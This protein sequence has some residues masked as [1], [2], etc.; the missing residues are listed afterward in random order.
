MLG[1]AM[2]HPSSITSHRPLPHQNQKASEKTMSGWSDR[3]WERRHDIIY[4][5]QVSALYHRKRERFYGFLDKFTSSLA[6]VAGSAAMSD[7]LSTTEAKSIAGGL[8]AI[9]TIPGIVFSWAERA[10]DHAVLASRF[11]ALEADVEGLG[12]TDES[13]FDAMM[14]RAISI[15]SEEPPQLATLTKICQN[16]VARASGHDD[17]VSEIGRFSRWT[18]HWL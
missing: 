4:K 7:F 5:C 18:A 6:L 15:E 16:E 12:V 10:K 3:A 2:G 9:V 13:A 8:V 14:Q 1:L 11:V 17:C